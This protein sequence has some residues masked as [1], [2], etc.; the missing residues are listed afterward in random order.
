MCSPVRSVIIPLLPRD[1]M[2]E[3]D[4]LKKCIISPKKSSENASLNQ[5]LTTVDQPKKYQFDVFDEISVDVETI[6]RKNDG[7]GT[8]LGDNPQ[9]NLSQIPRGLTPPRK[10]GPE[11]FSDI[12]PKLKQTSLVR[13]HDLGK[14]G[15]Q[16]DC[17]PSEE[18]KVRRKVARRKRQKKEDVLVDNSQRSIKSYFS[19]KVQVGNAL[20][21]KRKHEQ[22][23]TE[24]SKK[25]RV[26]ISD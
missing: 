10:V 6:N 12:I 7:L 2:I 15:V 16:S 8:S 22:S 19:E 5:K 23:P 9:K 24:K 11:R 20:N 4:S 13:L 21:G 26:G 3:S 1:K 18:K 25:L 17:L 14:L